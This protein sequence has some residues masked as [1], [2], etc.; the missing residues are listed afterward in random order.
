MLRHKVAN[1]SLRDGMFHSKDQIIIIII[2]KIVK[3]INL[4]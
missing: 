4:K 1:A 2:L 3:K